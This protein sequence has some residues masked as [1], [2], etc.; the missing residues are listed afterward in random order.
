MR[1]STTVKAG[2]M[3]LLVV[4]V[5]LAVW[6]SLRADNLVKLSKDMDPGFLV[7]KPAPMQSE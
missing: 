4:L 5:A 6:I 2:L 1:L 3:A 7:P